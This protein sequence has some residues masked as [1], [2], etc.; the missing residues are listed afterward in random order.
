MFA[1]VFRA[2]MNHQHVFPETN[3]LAGHASRTSDNGVRGDVTRHTF[4]GRG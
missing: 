3:E 2:L 4:G 1:Y